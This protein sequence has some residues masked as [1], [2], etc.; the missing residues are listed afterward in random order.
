LYLRVCAPARPRICLHWVLTKPRVSVTCFCT[1]K[2]QTLST[3]H[4]T[5]GVLDYTIA[6]LESEGDVAHDLAYKLSLDRATTNDCAAFIFGAKDRFVQA[7]SLPEGTR[8]FASA[9]A[10]ELVSRDQGLGNEDESCVVTRFPIGSE[11]RLVTD[12][13]QEHA[14]RLAEEWNRDGLRLEW[15]A[16]VYLNGIVIAEPHIADEKGVRRM[17]FRTMK[18]PQVFLSPLLEIAG[19][20]ANLPLGR[21]KEP[22]GPYFPEKLMQAHQRDFPLPLRYGYVS[23]V[24]EFRNLFAANLLASLP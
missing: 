9:S 3:E 23:T 8:F 14:E 5:I 2:E 7:V 11:H 1:R 21:L 6:H 22:I 24:T 15:I 13:H 18:P 16:A 12:V 4:L 20:P 10:L 19:I 17:N